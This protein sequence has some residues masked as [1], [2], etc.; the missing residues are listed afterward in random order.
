[1]ALVFAGLFVIPIL[2]RLR[3]RTV[4]EFVGLR[5]SRE[6]RGLTGIVWVFRYAFWLG[7][8]LYTA[9][10]AFSEVTGVGGLLFWLVLFSVIAVTYTVL[11]G[12][13]SVTITDVIQFVLMLGGALIMLPIIMYHVGWWPG[14]VSNL[15]AGHL[16]LIKTE[17][18]FN[19]QFVLAIFLLGIQWASTDQ[20]LAQMA[21]GSKDIKTVARGLV[22]AGIIT[23][24]FALLWNL[25]GLSAAIL[26]PGLENPD[27]AIPLLLAR[28]MPPV[29][30]GFI[31]CGLMSSQMSTISAYLNGTATLFTSDIFRNLI[32]REASP[33]TILITARIVTV[34]VGVS[35]IGF[36]YLIPKMGGA[37]KAYLTVVG[38]IDMPLFIIAIVWG[39]LWKRTT[40]QGAMFGYLFG[41]LS[42][43]VTIVFF[44]GTFNSATFASAF[45]ALITCP[46]VSLLTRAP[47]EGTLTAIWKAKKTSDEEEISGR[48]HIWPA[49]TGGKLSVLIWGVGLC[50]FLFGALSGSWQAAY[51]SSL[52]LWGMIIYFLGGLVRL[53][54]D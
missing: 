24:P 34:A 30:I 39:L 25:P 11:G 19:W 18:L 40:W 8:V 33:R 7:I 6:L 17:G 42:G 20:G 52:A 45:G 1:M 29:V 27:Q 22:M 41:I 26:T 36:A 51:A 23:T 31:L 38:C 10:L 9:A 14:L 4:P 37:V 21:L 43:V 3:I 49:S 5:Y 2:R 44:G 12:M 16:D 35:M 50:M 32:K 54:F 46:I 47:E 13:W 15:P 48:Y 53:R 28:Y